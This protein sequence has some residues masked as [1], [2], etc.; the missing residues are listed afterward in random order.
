MIYWKLGYE[1]Y[2][3]KKYEKALAAYKNAEK[4]NSTKKEIKEGIDACIRKI[5]N[6]NLNSTQ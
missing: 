3:E 5:Q 2:K 4:L 1:Y 6:I